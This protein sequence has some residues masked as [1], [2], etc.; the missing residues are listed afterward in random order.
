[1]LKVEAICTVTL[2][3]PCTSGELIIISSDTTVIS[4]QQVPKS[5]YRFDVKFIG[6]FKWIMEPHPI[7]KQAKIKFQL[8]FSQLSIFT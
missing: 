1:M 6:I 4:E 2:L 7:L 5:E 8:H 3:S